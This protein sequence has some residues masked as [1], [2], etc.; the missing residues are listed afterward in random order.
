MNNTRRQL[1]RWLSPWLTPAPWLAL[2]LLVVA[3]HSVAPR[4][5]FWCALLLVVLLVGWVQAL[6]GPRL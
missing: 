6:R 5:W 2:L 1:R 3:A 4:L